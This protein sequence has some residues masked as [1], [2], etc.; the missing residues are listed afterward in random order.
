M[1]T[2]RSRG[3]ETTSA[4]AP[5]RVDPNHPHRVR[6]VVEGRL[7]GAEDQEVDRTAGGDGGV[8]VDPPRRGELGVDQ[9]VHG[10]DAPGHARAGDHE[11]DEQPE[12]EGP[13]RPMATGSHRLS[14]P[15]RT[16][17]VLLVA[18]RRPGHHRGPGASEHEPCTLPL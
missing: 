18:R 16:G 9:R 8:D 5:A 11:R 4:C 15:P 12:E 3:N 2:H 1:L 10:D 14:A 17:T 13:N 6:E 7:V